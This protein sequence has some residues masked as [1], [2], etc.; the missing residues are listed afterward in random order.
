MAAPLEQTRAVL[1]GRNRKEP[2][3][4]LFSESV[5]GKK[6]A[7]TTFYADQSLAAAKRYA[8][9]RNWATIWHLLS[10]QRLGNFVEVFVSPEAQ[11]L[12]RRV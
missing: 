4:I 11:G 10:R 2:D 12:R 7:P 3:A 5:G 6:K 8:A 1:T 9:V